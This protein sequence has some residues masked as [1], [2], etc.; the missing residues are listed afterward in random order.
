MCVGKPLLDTR[1]PL[2]VLFLQHAIYQN[3][4]DS[5]ESNNT[6]TLPNSG[7]TSITTKKASS[8]TGVALI[9]KVFFGTTNSRRL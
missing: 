7:A 3:M 4:L 6:A 5:I 2:A 8:Q 9:D 1:T